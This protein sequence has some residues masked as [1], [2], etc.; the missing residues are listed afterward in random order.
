MIRSSLAGLLLLAVGLDSARAA[1][2]QGVPPAPVLVAPARAE[3]SGPAIQATGTVVSRN[4]ARLASEVAGRIEWIAEPGAAVARGA[5]IV[6][7]DDDRLALAVRDNDAAVRRLEANVGL[8]RTQNQRLQ[9]LAAQNIASRNQIDEAASRLAMA[10]QELEQARVAADRAR[11]DLRRATVR[12][13]FEGH[14]AERLQQAG[15]YVA[16][17]APLVRLVDTRNVEVVARA[18][19]G[20]A[21]QLAAGQPVRIADDS[22]TVEDRI[23]SVVPVGDER[24]RLLEVRVALAPGAWPIGAPVRVELSGA[25]SA[26]AVSV[27]RDAVVLRQGSS[28]VFRVGADD[29]AERV[30]VRTGAGRVDHVEVTGGIRAGDRVIVRGAE[31]LQPGQKVAVQAKG[32]GALAERR[33]GAVR[34]S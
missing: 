20:A 8:L 17:G 3:S 13:P 12:A 34:A 9:T 25:G 6:R 19:L 32:G 2:D 18:P 22:R 21:A 5:P 11:L 30:T 15:E 23:R 27:P 7:L 29:I 4:D 31:R 1:N 26:G 28:F 14:V 10:E 16:V 24:S 33:T